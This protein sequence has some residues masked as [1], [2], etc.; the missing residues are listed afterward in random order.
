MED[1]ETKLEIRC[2]PHALATVVNNLMMEM[3]LS[4]NMSG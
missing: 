1:D 2:V 4:I 3:G